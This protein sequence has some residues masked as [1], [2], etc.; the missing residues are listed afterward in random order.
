MILFQNLRKVSVLF[1][2]RSLGKTVQMVFVEKIKYD[3][4]FPGNQFTISYTQ[5]HKQFC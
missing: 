5:E 4:I 2:Y 3:N 1:K